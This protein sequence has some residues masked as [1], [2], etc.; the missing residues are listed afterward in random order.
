M[1]EQRIR[2]QKWR[3]AFYWVTGA[4]MLAASVTGLLV[5]IYQ[6]PPH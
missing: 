2:R 4:V 1:A 6:R 5:L 3:M